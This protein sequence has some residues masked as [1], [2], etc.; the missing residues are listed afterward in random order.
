MLAKFATG[1]KGT[2]FDAR[3]VPTGEF[4]DFRDGTLLEIE[5]REDKPVFVG[6]ERKKAFDEFAR[7]ECIGG[8][9]ARFGGGKVFQP[10]AFA[11]L[12][13]R[14]IAN[15]PFGPPAFG[16]KGIETRPHCEPGKPVLERLAI[17]SF[18]LIE[19]HK[20]FEEDF[21]REI[22]FRDSPRKMTANDAD[23]LWIEMFDERPSR[24]IVASSHLV[25]AGGDI[26]FSG[27]HLHIALV[28][29]RQR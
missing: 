7:S 28:S 8:R 27:R 24:I 21:L 23:D 16:S 3:C 4:G 5:E 2:D 19:P 20:H 22:L 15:A 17:A 12:E 25:E 18:V 29:K 13:Q 11:A 14:Q 26:E 1:A 6:K 9:F 10:V